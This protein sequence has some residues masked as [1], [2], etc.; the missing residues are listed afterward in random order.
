MRNLSTT[1]NSETIG[2]DTFFEASRYGCHKTICDVTKVTYNIYSCYIC[3]MSREMMEIDSR[4]SAKCR[5]S[6]LRDIDGIIEFVLNDN[7]TKLFIVLSS[8]NLKETKIGVER[9][10]GGGGG[11]GTVGSEFVIF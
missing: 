10:E 4:D 1:S 3:F 9:G 2:V 5:K 6:K 7:K 8:P 11:G